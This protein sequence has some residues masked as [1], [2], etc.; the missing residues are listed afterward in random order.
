[1]NVFTIIL[2]M[3]IV[4]TFV[5]IIII[6]IRKICLK[7]IPSILLCV[8]WTVLMFR[9]ICPVSI[10][11]PLS[12]LNLIIPDVEND[13]ITMTYTEEWSH[14]QFP[15]VQADA[16]DKV[17]G[18][19]NEN[20]LNNG[21]DIKEIIMVAASILWI[22]GVIG[23]FFYNLIHYIKV[24]RRIRTATILKLDMSIA[25]EKVLR[26]KRHIKVYASDKIDTPFVFGILIPKIY[27]PVSYNEHQL[28]YVLI[29][30]LVHI[31]RWDHRVKP[32]AYMIYILHWFNPIVWLAIRH[33]NLD[34]EMACDEKVI[35]ILGK[36]NRQDYAHSLLDC[37]LQKKRRIPCWQSSYN[38]NYLTVRVKNV[39]GYKEKK[40]YEKI[41]LFTSVIGIV[42]T[43][44]T[45]PLILKHNENIVPINLF[46]VSWGK[47]HW[48]SKYIQVS[49]QMKVRMKPV[50]ENP[51]SQDTITQDYNITSEKPHLGIDII[52]TEGESIKV[53]D[54]GYV[55]FIGYDKQYGD[56]IKVDHGQGYVSWY[57]GYKELNVLEN[58]TVK[59][60]QIIGAIGYTGTGPHLHFSILYNGEFVD[61]KDYLSN[62]FQF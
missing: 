56:I 44:S 11:N 50:Y 37:V 15:S 17:L 14:I 4:S 46:K 58:E 36:E 23:L 49:E 34:I 25:F 2:S 26:I 57:S 38:A 45:N 52:A 8:L 24:G 7:R 35:R 10:A 12:L 28:P 21:A 16:H 22:L 30:E 29:H 43:L 42:L 33:M 40:I 3:S 9:L 5:G 32:I 41:L 48:V 19:E 39:I 51:V 1:M 53:V 27:V 20:M 61:P 60:G 47:E 55:T 31:K 62:T 59:K 13:M 18:A 54:D 6:L